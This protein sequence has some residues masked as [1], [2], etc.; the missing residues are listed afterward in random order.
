MWLSH[1]KQSDPSNPDNFH[2]VSLASCCLKI[3][4]HLIHMRVALFINQQLRPSQGGFRWGADARV[5]SLVTVLM[6]PSAHTFET[7]VDIKNAFDTAWVEARLLRLHDVGVRGLLWRLISNLLRC[8]VFQVRL[9]GEFSEP[10]PD[11]GIAQGRILSPLLFNLLVDGFAVAT[12]H[13]SPRVLLPGCV[14]SRFTAQLCVDDLVIAAESPSDL[15]TA[16]NAVSDW[17]FSISLHLVLAPT[18]QRSWCSGPDAVFQNVMS[19]WVESVCQKCR[20]TSVSA[21]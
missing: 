21:L 13:A 20:P 12:H 2:L 5:G 10:W 3:L 15:Q 11:S 14:G 7:F 16:L 19:S 8:T 4:E 17:G 18:N 9:G 6:C 1:F